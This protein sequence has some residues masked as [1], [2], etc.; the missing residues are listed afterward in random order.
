MIKIKRTIKLFDYFGKPINLI[1]KDGFIQNTLCG[2]VLS[3]FIIIL[4]LTYGCLN[5]VKI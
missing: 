3:I 5:A 4:V 1:Y 2:G